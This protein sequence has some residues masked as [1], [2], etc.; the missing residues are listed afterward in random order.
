MRHLLSNQ[1]ADFAA[2]YDSDVELISVQ[3]PPSN[4]LES[5]AEKLFD[6]RKVVE[7][8]WQQNAKDANAPFQALRTS[9]EDESL[10]KLAQ[11]ITTASDIL[12]ELLGCEQVGIR[13]A[14]LSSPMCPRFHADQV[15][16][17]L[18]VTIG[19]HGTEWIASNDVDETALADRESDTPPIRNN[20]KIRQLTKGCWSLLKGG[21]WQE[22]FRGVVHRSPHQAGQR[23]LLTFDPIF[24][25]WLRS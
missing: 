7:L 8:Q 2:I 24:A 17:R 15:P 6:T 23:L 9:I 13:V 18:L 3:R 25:A 16:C 4:A 19:G 12:S 21:A 14:T 5:L 1:I 20:G 10:P 22:Q 11:E